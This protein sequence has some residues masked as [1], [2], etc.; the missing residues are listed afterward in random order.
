MRHGFSEVLSKSTT[1][2]LS[3]LVYYILQR[4]FLRFGDFFKEAYNPSVFAE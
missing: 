4:V 2:E 1:N 3:E